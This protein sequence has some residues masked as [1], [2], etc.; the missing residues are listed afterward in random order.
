[1]PFIFLNIFSLFI[2][3]FCFISCLYL[4]QKGLKAHSQLFHLFSLYFFLISINQLILYLYSVP[5]SNYSNYLDLLLLSGILVALI[6]LIP[7]LIIS[8]S[9]IKSSKKKYLL[10]ELLFIIICFIGLSVFF[11]RSVSNSISRD[12]DF[13]TSYTILL[14]ISFLIPYLFCLINL[15]DNLNSLSPFVKRLRIFL[16]LGIIITL[17]KLIATVSLTIETF[18]INFSFF[19]V[20]GL[21]FI[22]QI[23]LVVYTLPSTQSK[24]K[25][26]YY[27]QLN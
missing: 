12:I 9:V 15:K 25:E 23:F 14:L 26:I 2:S 19:D 16:I 3:I 21:L 24:M 22:I 17:T 5:Y 18:T 4:F 27:L 20:F 7:V 10:L 11:P 1:M 8:S 13:S 6:S